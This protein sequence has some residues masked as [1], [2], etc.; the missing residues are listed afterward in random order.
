MATQTTI[1]QQLPPGYV[2]GI[3]EQFSDYFMGNK[4]LSGSPFFADPNQM[5]GGSFNPATGQFTGITG[6]NVPASDFFVAGQDAMQTDA[7]AIATGQQ[8]APTTGLG[9][10]QDYVTQADQMNTL[11]QGIATGPVAGTQALADAAG[12]V[13]DADLAATA[14]QNAATPF[15]QQAQQFA[16]PQG[17]Q[18]F[19]SP[20]QEQVINATM[21][22]FDQDAAEAAA[23]FGSSAGSAYGGGRFG[24]AEGQLAADTANQR[25][26]LQ[27]QLLNQGFMQSQ[28]LANQAVQN[29]INM[30]QTALGNALQNV[31]LFGQTAG[32]QGALSG[33]QQGLQAAQLANL[34]GVGNQA[35]N[36][37]GFGQ[38]GIG[39]LLNT[40]TTMGQQ[41]Q[42]Y[43]QAIQD[44]LAALATGIQLAPTQTMGNL[45]QFL[46]AAYGTP[47]STTYQ[48]TPAPSTL[49]TLLGGGIGLA[50]IIGALKG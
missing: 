44:Q 22:Q 4:P 30:G 25:A 23:Q 12:T 1:Q 41:N 40:Y 38:T 17:F 6:A 2:T 13:A 50:G 5:F 49:Q 29:Q 14:G 15:L 34:T 3:G 18:Q 8:A 9:Q 24:V 43:N 20:Y 35:L 32:M 31:G 36:I 46:S 26:L 33:Q 37:G 28:G 10:Y 11:A 21:A 48:Q 27:A 42:L 16:G 45:G 47:S 19:M 39:N 7:Q